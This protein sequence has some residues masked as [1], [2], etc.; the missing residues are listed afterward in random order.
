VADNVIRSARAMSD[1]IEAVNASPNYLSTTIRA[2]DEKR[3]GMM[4]IYKLK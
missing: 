3:D 4:V 2:D 1:F